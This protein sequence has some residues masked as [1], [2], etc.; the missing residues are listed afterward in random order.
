MSITI[1]LPEELLT[2]LRHLA[3]VTGQSIELVAKQ[4]LVEAVRNMSHS[5]LRSLAGSWASNVS[6]AGVKAEEYLGQALFDELHQP[7]HDIRDE[8]PRR[9][10]GQY[11]GQIWMAPDFDEWPEEMQEAWS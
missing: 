2:S 1:E 3:E 6:D 11:A 4:A 9:K 5:R 8:L 10:G 7:A